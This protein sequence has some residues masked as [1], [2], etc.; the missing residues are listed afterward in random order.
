M[1]PLLSAKGIYSVLPPFE[2]SVGGIYEC[3]ALRKY[4]DLVELG[5]DV[6][7]EYYLP[8]SITEVAYKED[9]EAGVVLVTLVDQHGQY[10]YIPDSYITGYPNQEDLT[11]HHVVL[12]MSMGP[13][14]DTVSL[15]FLKQQLAEKA[16]EV[17][18]LTPLI[19]SN[20]VPM[21]GSINQ[22][23]HD[24]MEAAR[25]LRI[26]ERKTDAVKLAEAEQKADVAEERAALLTQMCIDAGLIEVN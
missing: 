1:T 5:V 24:I 20:F 11:Y 15:D 13:L 9:V 3:I 21:V 4:D 2:L 10:L 23:Q 17:I 26:S 16:S 7:E 12:G 14:P 18:G 8:H 6:Y 25:Q 19:T 22:E